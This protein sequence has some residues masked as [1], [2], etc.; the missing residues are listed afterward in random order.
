MVN[1]SMMR[2]LAEERQ[3]DMLSSIPAPHESM[4]GAREPHA[5]AR[6]VTA[7]VVH[8]GRSVAEHF[9]GVGRHP[10]LHKVWH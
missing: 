9:S 6:S 10:A 8:L 3:R 1:P 4:S 5:W 2:Q 7:H